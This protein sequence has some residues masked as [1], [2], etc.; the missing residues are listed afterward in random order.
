MLEPQK[1]IAQLQV[2]ITENEQQLNKIALALADNTVILQNL[3]DQLHHLDIDSSKKRAMTDLCL[4]LIQ[5]EATAK[6]LGIELSEIE[7][8]FIH[9]LEKKHP[10][11]KN[12][13]LKICLLIKHDYDNE[14]IARSSGIM[15]RGVE[16]IRYRIHK[17]LGIAKNAPIKIYLANHI[18][19]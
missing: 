18:L 4:R 7:A 14:E 3:L 12:R 5:T 6:R 16:S 13:E 17:K 2:K 10:N 8:L 19:G 15:S 1:E 11:L 9:R